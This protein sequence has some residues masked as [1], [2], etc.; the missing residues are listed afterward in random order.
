VLRPFLFRRRVKCRRDAAPGLELPAPLVVYGW[1]F[2]LTDEVKKLHA[3][4]IFILCIALSLSGCTALLPRSES[5]AKSTWATYENARE[6]FDLITPNKTTKED[7]IEFGFNP[8]SNPNI[9]V[10]TYSDVIRRFVPSS[11]VAEESLDQGIRECIVAKEA[12]TAYEID[13][14]SLKRKRTGNFWLDALNF[15]RRTDISGWRFNGIIVMKDDVVVY[16]LHG[17]QPLIQEA[18]ENRNPLGPFQGVVESAA[19]RAGP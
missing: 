16:K 12:C 11:A 8:Y 18:E 9:S 4:P 1:A 5:G 7:L 2:R 17:G 6:T 14:K 19:R 13:V 3:R 15:K 10:L